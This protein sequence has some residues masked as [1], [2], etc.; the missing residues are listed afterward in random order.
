MAIHTPKTREDL[1]RL[2]DPMRLKATPF[3]RAVAVG[4]AEKRTVSPAAPRSGPE[5][6]DG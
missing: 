2:L 3:E 6:T 5:F 4:A 1:G